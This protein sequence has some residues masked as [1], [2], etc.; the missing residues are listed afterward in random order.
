MQQ[1]P[2]FYD[3][4]RVVFNKRHLNHRRMLEGYGEGGWKRVFQIVQ[5]KLS[6]IARYTPNTNIS[7]PTAQRL[8]F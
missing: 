6:Q 3:A 1:V 8:N 4:L 2:G 5:T 7:E